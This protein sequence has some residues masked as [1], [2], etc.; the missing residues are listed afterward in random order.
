VAAGVGVIEAAIGVFLD[1]AGRVPVG[2][3]GVSWRAWF[4]G[5]LTYYGHRRGCTRSTVG[6]GL[7]AMEVNDDAG[8]LTPRGA[9]GFFAGKLLQGNVCI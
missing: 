6:A 8:S 7:P 3:A 1:Q 2:H 4:A 5:I 9:L